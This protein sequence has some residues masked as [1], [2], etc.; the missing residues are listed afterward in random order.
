[1][2]SEVVELGAKLYEVS[3]HLQQARESSY[4]H[5]T[6]SFG[7]DDGNDVEEGRVGK[8]RRR[9]DVASN[10]G[11]TIGGI[12]SLLDRVRSGSG[13]EEKIDVEG[14]KELVCAIKRERMAGGGDEGGTA[15][16]TPLPPEVRACLMS[17]RRTISKALERLS[18]ELYSQ[19]SRCIM[20]LIQNADDNLYS[21][22]GLAGEGPPCL[23]VE[24][25]VGECLLAY[26]NEDGFTAEDVYAICQVG[27]SFKQKP[28]H[29]LQDV[30]SNCIKTR[31]RGR[32]TIGKVLLLLS[33]L[34]LLLL[35]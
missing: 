11:S 1:M 34:L 6:S 13:G 33:L 28:Q 8:K 30:S 27:E 5:G 14:A 16:T 9:E 26:H 7:M 18:L 23:T 32:S 31:R 22:K 35:L 15:T 20:E 29:H 21:S 12:T 4:Y 17:S 2:S 3:S 24:L 19:R 25:V 10:G